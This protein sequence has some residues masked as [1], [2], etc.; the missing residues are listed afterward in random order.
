MKV[1]T[2][3]LL[4]ALKR[5]KHTVFDQGEYNLNIV[6]VR[7]KNPASNAFDDLICLLYK[8]RGEWVLLPFEATTDPGTFYLENP[9]NVNGTAIV[10]PGQYPGLWTMGKHQGKYLALVQSGPV[11]VHRDNNR[12]KTQNTAKTESGIFG[13]NCHRA[14]QDGTSVQV[15]RWSAG[16]QVFADS[17]EYAIFMA[18]CQKALTLWGNSFSY[19]LLEEKDLIP[20]EK[21]K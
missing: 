9:I 18:I 7:A 16:C 8:K 21:K 20:P 5:K 13:I 3:L 12:D 4:D 15:G 11:T 6:G 17:G 1:N 19:T 10:K 14:S 2:Q